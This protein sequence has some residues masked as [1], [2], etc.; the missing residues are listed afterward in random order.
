MKLR[1]SLLF[2]LAGL[3][4][5]HIAARQNTGRSLNKNAF[6]GALQRGRCHRC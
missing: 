1:I 4:T 5:I 6:I 3:L 2:A